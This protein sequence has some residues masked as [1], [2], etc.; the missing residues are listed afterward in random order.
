MDTH[1]APHFEPTLN[2][3]LQWLARAVFDLTLHATA[4]AHAVSVTQ[5]TCDPRSGRRRG[6]GVRHKGMRRLLLVLL[7]GVA[8]VL[9]LLV[10]GLKSLE[11][12]AARR[13]IASALSESMGQPV[14][15]GRL[16]VTLL[17][18]PALAARA[19]RIGNAIATRLRRRAG[20]QC[21]RASGSTAAPVAPSGPRSHHRGS[22]ARQRGHH[23]AARQH[24]TMAAAA[25]E[26]ASDQHR[27]R[28]SGRGDRAGRP[29]DHPRHH[30]AVRRPPARQR[31]PESHHHYRCSGVGPRGRRADLRVATL[32]QARRDAR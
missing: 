20:H 14:T 12:E 29:P 16:S 32:G 23:R 17:P 31:R 5:F 21:Q 6:C 8:L 11:T 22:G 2:Y 24:R 15:L 27:R 7:G 18:K 19:I 13:R 30:S 1:G 4:K 25:S 26:T 3:A 9:V 10:V 28:G